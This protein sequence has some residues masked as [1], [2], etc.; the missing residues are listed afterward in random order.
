MSRERPVQLRVSVD[1]CV[2]MPFCHLRPKVTELK[3]LVF[4]KDYTSNFY[5]CRD[6]IFRLQKEVVQSVLA[7]RQLSVWNSQP[8]LFRLKVKRFDM[9]YFKTPS[10]DFQPYQRMDFL[11][12]GY[13]SKPQ[14]FPLVNDS[15]IAL[16]FVKMSL[17]L[18]PVFCRRPMYYDFF[19]AALHR[20]AFGA[21]SVDTLP[22]RPRPRRLTR[23]EKRL[24]RV[25]LY[26]RG[27]TSRGSSV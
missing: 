6:Q 11:C 15:H 16:V 19:D 7:H 5:C 12:Q 18:V 14:I 25:K 24:A 10:G 23:P 22:P 3:G 26:K 20:R 4:S 8:H 2:L 27:W 17:E 9:F 13:L 21:K 1:Y